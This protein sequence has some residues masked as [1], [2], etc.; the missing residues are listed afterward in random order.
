MAYDPDNDDLKEKDE[1][2]SVEQKICNA[3]YANDI[4]K[5]KEILVLE[6]DYDLNKLGAYG[7]K[8]TQK[9]TPLHIACNK[10]SLKACKE[11]IKFKADVNVKAFPSGNTPLHIAAAWAQHKIVAI[12]LKSGAEPVA[13]NNKN[14]NNCKNDK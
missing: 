4:D 7:K 3:I 14:K 5:L 1:S 11:L 9:I 13:N 2:V 6:D 8:G 12:L 10:K